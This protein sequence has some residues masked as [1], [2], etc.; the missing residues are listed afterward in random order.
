MS[1]SPDIVADVRFYSTAEGGRQQVTPATMFACILVI[2]GEN[3]DCRLLLEGIGPV[4]P[5]QTVR[6]PIKFLSPHLLKHRLTK[7]TH[8][9]LRELRTIAEGVVS[10]ALFP[11]VPKIRR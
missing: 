8:F 2:S 6:V 9:H 1:L 4:A 11:T 3:F 10:E 5:G 7:G